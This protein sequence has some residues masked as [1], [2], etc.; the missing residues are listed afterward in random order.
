MEVP[1]ADIA[2]DGDNRESA[3]AQPAV[4]L[5]RYQPPIIKSNRFIIGQ[6]Q[7]WKR[8]VPAGHGLIFALANAEVIGASIAAVVF[9][10]HLLGSRNKLR[11]TN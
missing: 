8:N 7:H 5:A 2:Y 11:P 4:A 1:A 9:C 6:L 3:E 10:K